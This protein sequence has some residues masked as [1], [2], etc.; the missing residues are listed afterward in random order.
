MSLILGISAFYHDS[1]AVLLKDGKISAAFQEERFTRIKQDNSFPVNAIK[2]CLLQAGINF[3]EIDCVCYYEDPAK[4]FQRI[5]TTY[6]KNIPKGIYNFIVELPSWVTNKNIKKK[7]IKEFK[8]NFNIFWDKDKIFFSEH[9]LSHA[10]SAFYASPFQSSAILC[11]DGVGEWATTSVWIGEGSKLT[12]C[13]QIDFPHSLGLLYS[14]FTYFCGFKVDSGEYKLMGL[15]PYGEPKYK[16]TILGEMVSVQDNGT[17]V[18]N[19]SYFD[20]ETGQEMTSKKFAKLFGG[21]RRMPESQI[22]QRE[23]DLAASIQVVTEDIV[24][25]LAAT[26]RK[27][28][29]KEFLCLAGGVALNCVANG[30]LLRSGL[31][32]DIWVQPAA[33]DAGCALGA[34]YYYY[35]DKQRHSRI[36]NGKDKMNGSYLGNEYGNDIIKGLLDQFGAVY[37]FLEDQELIYKSAQALADEKVV[38]WFQDRMEFGPRALGARSILGN[39]QGKTMQSIMNLKIKNRE[40]FRPFAPAILEE[41]LTDWFE[42]DRSSPY[43]LFVAPVHQKQRIAFNDRSNDSLNGFEKLKLL[44]STIPAVSHVD[45]SARIQTVNSSYNERF[46]RLIKEFYKITSCPVIINTSFNVRGEPIVEN[47]KDAYQCFMRTGMDYLVMGNYFLSK[48]DQPEWKENSNWKQIY[49]LD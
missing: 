23:M 15:A 31:F 20:Y 36:L 9:H 41:H 8:K 45:L 21:N 10:A 19:M 27:E 46:Y 35:Y 4:K 38:G 48:K 42:L 39:P 2:H 40:S 3:E 1:A 18:L 33:G 24:L 26:V 37:L 16:D 32:K 28:T 22:T 47:P 6:L 29:K 14:A 25:K 44:R 7:L 12:P 5:L 30:K 34:A 11:L 49:A 43:M 17:F 13:W